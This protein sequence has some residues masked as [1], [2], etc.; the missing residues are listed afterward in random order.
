MFGSF[1]DQN[2]T[3]DIGLGYSTNEIGA[4]GA[5]S[6]F[7]YSPHKRSLF[8]K[9]DNGT[10]NGVTV[11]NLIAVMG[12]GGLNPNFTLN[13][14]PIGPLRGWNYFREKDQI[15]LGGNYTNYGATGRNRLAKIDGEGNLI[16]SFLCNLNDTVRGCWL[17]DDDSVFCAGNFTVVNGVG[18]NRVVKLNSTG[19]IDTSFSVGTGFNST[20]FQVIKMGDKYLYCGLFNAYK[21]S[22]IKR[23]LAL[24]DSSGNLDT[25]FN[26]NF[27]GVGTNIWNVKILNNGDI[28]IN[29]NIVTLGEQPCAGVAILNPDGSTKYRDKANGNVQAVA[30]DYD[31]NIYIGGAFTQ[32]DGNS[33][34]GVAKL[35]PELEYVPEFT[36]N[37][38]DITAVSRPGFMYDNW[39]KCLYLDTIQPYLSTPTKGILKVHLNG[40]VDTK[41]TP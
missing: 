21:S 6:D 16:N 33:V 19:A 38:Q 24:L 37:F 8:T 17:E 39:H 3:M 35:T 15:L 2:V 40:Y 25:T 22:T 41:W 26:T 5:F 34:S 9:T 14:T 23:G 11:P 29:G 10:Y 18:R 27:E 31:G 20:T 13:P 4:T 32:Y 1:L 36:A 28:L 30:V 7:I 12:G